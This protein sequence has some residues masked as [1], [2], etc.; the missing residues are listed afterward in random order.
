MRQTV[1][2]VL[3]AAASLV[4]AAAGLWGLFLVVPPVY[5]WMMRY[6][7]YLAV[8]AVFV[9]APLI[10]AVAQKTAQTVIVSQSTD[11]CSNACL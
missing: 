3:K 4:F 8:P 1:A 7:G 2:T 6:V 10:A 5:S 9:A 11:S